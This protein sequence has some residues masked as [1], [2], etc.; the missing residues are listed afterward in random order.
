MTEPNFHAW[1]QEDNAQ[2]ADEICTYFHALDLSDADWIPATEYWLKRAVG[3]M[4]DNG[5]FD[6]GRIRPLVADARAAGSS[7]DRIGELVGMSAEA[8][9]QCFGAIDETIRA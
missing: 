5:D 9:Q 1:A 4:S 2:Y 8:A 6:D 3:R 7:W